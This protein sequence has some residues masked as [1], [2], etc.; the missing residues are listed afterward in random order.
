MS[1]QLQ[2]QDRQ[3][4]G[5]ARN[6]VNPHLPQLVMSF[7]KEVNHVTVSGAP[8]VAC[9]C[10]MGFCKQRLPFQ[11]AACRQESLCF[12]GVRLYEAEAEIHQT[13]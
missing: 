5:T 2:L 4:V 1:G 6:T 13:K 12:H 10:K 3:E 11:T 8:L 9:I 7:N